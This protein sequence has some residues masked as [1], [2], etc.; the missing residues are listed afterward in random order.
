MPVR[1]SIIL[2]SG[3]AIGD[4]RFSRH[5]A[6]QFDGRRRLEKETGVIESIE[7]EFQKAR[8]RFNA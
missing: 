6:H 1:N 2:A 4:G 7:I 5:C 3:T 8:A